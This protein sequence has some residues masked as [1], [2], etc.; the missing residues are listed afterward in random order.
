MGVS[1]KEALCKIKREYIYSLHFQANIVRKTS[2]DISENH[3]LGNGFS[4]HETKGK[5]I[6]CKGTCVHTCS[7]H[8]YAFLLS[9]ASVIYA[10]KCIGIVLCHICF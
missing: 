2:M 8:F 7:L 5:V 9:S 1:R 3:G 6:T 10:E 4:H